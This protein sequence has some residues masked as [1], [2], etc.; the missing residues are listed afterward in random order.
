MSE[1]FLNS[2]QISPSLEQ[3]GGEGVA[4]EVRVDA[5]GLEACL[6]GEPA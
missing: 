1:Q 2:S 6:V 3:V 5:A 4:Q